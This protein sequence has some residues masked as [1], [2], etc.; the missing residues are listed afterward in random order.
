M[1]GDL[2][3]VFHCRDGSIKCNKRALAVSEHFFARIDW[4][5][6][7]DEFYFENC[8]RESVKIY[9]DFIHGLKVLR[10][11]LPLFLDLMKFLHCDERV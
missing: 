4:T 11:E 3:V 5:A 7:H 8:S 10:P 9:L 1:K 6:E 2:G